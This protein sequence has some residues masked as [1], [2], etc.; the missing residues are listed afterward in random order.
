M[1]ILLVS[2][3]MPTIKRAC[4]R[5]ILLDK[6]KMLFQG[7]PT[8]AIAEYQKMVGGEEV[9][10]N[11]HTATVIEDSPIRLAG[12]TWTTPGG[13]R[14]EI[15]A[16]KGVTFTIDY[17]ATA[18]V[19]DPAFHLSI[20]S[21]DRRVYTGWDSGYS[22]FTAGQLLPGRGS[23]RL[24]VPYFGIEPGAYTVSLG[25]WTRDGFTAY[26]WCAD[27]AQIVVSGDKRFMGCFELLARWEGREGRRLDL[28]GRRAVNPAATPR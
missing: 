15:E 19:E 6:G 25:I 3:H 17:E 21:P 18:V 22:G 4:P 12:L 13:E 27:F 5:V 11:D 24:T 23:I 7:D 26:D 16:G 20:I 14:G 1:T 8:T 28:D 9:K 2:H 10:G